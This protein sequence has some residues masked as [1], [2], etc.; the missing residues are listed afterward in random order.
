MQQSDQIEHRPVGSGV[1][2]LNCPRCGSA[3]LHQGTV[4]V[5]DRGE[6]QAACVKTVVEGGRVSVDP[7]GNNT[8]NPSMRRHGLTI[9]FD[10]EG[11]GDKPIFLTV[12]QHKGCTEIGWL[13]EEV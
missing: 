2:E 12:A 13:F 10:C 7:Y 11:C 6:D 1:S 5:Y 4:T 9:Q 3:Y 8:D